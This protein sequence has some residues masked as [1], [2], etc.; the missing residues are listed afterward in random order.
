MYT[1]EWVDFY[2]ALTIQCYWS[3][4]HQRE[5]VTSIKWIWSRYCRE[6]LFQTKHSRAGPRPN[7][8]IGHLFAFILRPRGNC[9]HRNCSILLF[10]LHFLSSPRRRRIGT[11]CRST[12][13]KIAVW[14]DSGRL[15]LSF[16]RWFPFECNY[17]FYKL[18]GVL[19][20]VLYI[21]IIF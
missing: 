20:F 16:Q 10:F 7:S 2:F 6:E 11:Y 4:L 1:L 15:N 8:P 12:F 18:N 19:Y 5:A 21:C 17:A 13:M 14:D 9:H 3:S